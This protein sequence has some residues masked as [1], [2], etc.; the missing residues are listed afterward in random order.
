[1]LIGIMSEFSS[2]D[3]SSK[4]DLDLMRKLK[5]KNIEN[6][7]QVPFQASEPAQ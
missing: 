4:K 2:V 3:V 5:K 7:H 6:F 1:M